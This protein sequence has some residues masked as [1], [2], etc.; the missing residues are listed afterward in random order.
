M[1]T[2]FGRNGNKSDM[3][4][5]AVTCSK[6]ALWF[7][8]FSEYATTGLQMGNF[9]LTGRLEQISAAVLLVT[10]VGL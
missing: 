7:E 10:V 8:D 2:S 3:V 6:N 4:A 5:A 9:S 1:K